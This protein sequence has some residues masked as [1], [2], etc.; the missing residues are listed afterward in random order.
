MGDPL[1][2][3]R[4]STSEIRFSGCLIAGP[5]T[6]FATSSTCSLAPT[7]S[8]C[9]NTADVKP[10]EVLRS[11]SRAASLPEHD[12]AGALH[13]VSN[14]L[15]VVLG[16]L[17]RAIQDPESVA[18]A[19]QVA[20]SQAWLGYRVARRAIGADVV[21]DSPRDASEVASSALEAVRCEAARKNV[22]LE[23]RESKEEGPPVLDA[24]AVAQQILLNLLLNAIAFTPSG[25]SVCLAWQLKSGRVAFTVKDE[26]PGVE[27]SRAATLLQGRSSTRP[28]GAGIG[29][30]HSVGLARAHGADLTLLNSGPG[31]SFELQWPVGEARS[32][33]R[34]AGVVAPIEQRRI[35]VL[36]DDPTVAELL[37]L[38]LGAKGAHVC[39]VSSLDEL[40]VLPREQRHADAALVDLSPLSGDIVGGLELTQAMVGEAPVVL[41]TGRANPLPPGAEHFVAAWVRK[42]F[43]MDEL[44]AVLGDV[45]QA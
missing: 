29:L 8:Y 24:S 17:D 22:L 33:A 43:D 1:T 20:R 32:G 39:I 15:T 19:L 10:T 14:S 18:R 34:H 38:S 28:G 21:E 9:N 27:R 37:Q 25:R 35:V 5:D 30:S 3:P 4:P 12:L 23:L 36:E 16:W 40:C 2:E 42:P 13:E 45:I 6:R 7:P 44:V 11:G 41:I 26:G 31:S